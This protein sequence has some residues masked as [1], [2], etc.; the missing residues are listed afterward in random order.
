QR[1]GARGLRIGRA[2]HRANHHEGENR[3]PDRHWKFLPWKV[4]RRDY[5]E[6]ASAVTD[7]IE[8]EQAR[9]VDIWKRFQVPSR[10]APLDC[11]PGYCCGPAPQGHCAIWSNSGVSDAANSS[12]KC[13]RGL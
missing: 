10:K 6:I 12:L 7:L 11:R 1:I 3:G 9:R 8:I 5:R 2:T 13:A 4:R